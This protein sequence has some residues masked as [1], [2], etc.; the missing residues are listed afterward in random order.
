MKRLVAYLEPFTLALLAT[1]LLASL[2]PARGGSARL[3]DLIANGA[4]MLLFFMHGAKLNREAV[5]TGLTN[6]RLHALVLATSFLLFPLFGLLARPLAQACGLDPVL[7]TGILYLTCL[8]STVQS[9]IAFVSIARGNVAA[10]VCAASA[11]NLL[12]ILATPLLVGVLLGAH[13]GF[14]LGSIGTL[15]GQLLLP[16]VA[17]QMLHGRL[18]GWMARNKA[19]LGI[20][21]RSAILLMVYSAFGEAVLGGL[22]SRVSI[23]EILLVLAVASLLLMAVLML[24]SVTGRALGFSEEDRITI[25]FCGSKKSLVTGVPMANVLFPAAVAGTMVLPLMIFHQI[26][27][28][29][30]AV[31]ARRFANRPPAKAIVPGCTTI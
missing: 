26:Q 16:F 12:G 9:S 21:D 13:G 31:L 4:V 24:T 10:A 25:I 14:A 19:W 3:V 1:V 18:G 8:P 15:L 30:C 22:W 20:V 5:L 23:A 11:S 27:L 2:I 7:A 29:V 6:W 17:G 28:I